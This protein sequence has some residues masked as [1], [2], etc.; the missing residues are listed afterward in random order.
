MIDENVTFTP[1]EKKQ[2]QREIRALQKR[3]KTMH[4]IRDKMNQIGRAHV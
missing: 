3:I 1:A 4:D 2:K